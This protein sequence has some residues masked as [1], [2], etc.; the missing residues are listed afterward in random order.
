MLGGKK[1]KLPCCKHIFD[2][3]KAKLAK[4]QPKNHQNVPKTHFLQKVPGV[5]GLT[6]VFYMGVNSMRADKLLALITSILNKKE[7]FISGQ[8]LRLCSSSLFLFVGLFM[9]FVSVR[10]F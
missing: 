1:G 8:F 2:R 5:N 9:T 10:S 3:S 6:L 7:D 4:I